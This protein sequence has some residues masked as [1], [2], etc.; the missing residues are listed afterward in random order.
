ME[1]ILNQEEI[2]KLFRAAQ[3]GAAAAPAATKRKVVQKCD[4]RQAGQLTKNQVRQVTQLH[5]NLAPNLANSL[6]AYLR[7]A[8]QIRLVSV[9]QLS[10]DEFLGRLPEQTYFASTLLMPVEESAGIQLDLS[11]S[12]PMIDLLLGGPGQGLA[13]PRD[14][15]EIEEQ[16][17]ESVVAIFCREMQSTWQF[18]LPL[19]FAIGQRL[20]QS[21]IYSLMS[22]GE[23]VLNLSFEIEL[24]EIHGA[25]NFVFPA[26]V[27]NMLLRKLSE[28]VAVRRK[29]SGD[30]AIRLRERLAGSLFTLELNLNR[31]PVQIRD[32]VAMQP[33]ELLQLNHS[34]H[35]PMSI[36]INNQPVFSATPVSCDSLRA[37]LIQ[38]RLPLPERTKK[39]HT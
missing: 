8:F 7:V 25:L 27:S 26:V 24:N 30:S 36:T 15:T 22:A 3:G 6:G 4:F 35:Q 29:S 5:E 2:D 34:V 39:D 21:Q 12:F 33:G 10:Y 32:L 17:L 19:E 28:Q 14:L 38:E 23:R 16:I 1:K 11:L 13:E 31:V 9:E 20:K 18:T 37:G